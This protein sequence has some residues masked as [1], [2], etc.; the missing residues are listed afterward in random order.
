MNNVD[1]TA[2]P[3]RSQDA[4]DVDALEHASPPQI[5]AADE[6]NTAEPQ[7][8]ASPVE[9]ELRRTVRHGRIIVS[10]VVVGA[11]IAMILSLTFPILEGSD[12]SL[13]QIVGFMMLIGAAIGLA[14]GAL[15]GLM[16]SLVVRNRTGGG[17]AIQ[18]DVR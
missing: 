4:R 12:Y 6:A 11:V 15:I 17:L 14:V 13:G 1:P 9:V 18:T 3:E 2:T 10:G 5:G 8:I 16:L 7:P